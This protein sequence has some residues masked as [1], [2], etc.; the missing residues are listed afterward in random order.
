MC[1]D[2]GGNT[3]SEVTTTDFIH[4]TQAAFILQ[5]FISQSMMRL[6]FSESILGIGQTW[7]GHGTDYPIIFTPL[8]I[9]VAWAAKL[10]D[11]SRASMW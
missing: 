11:K 1:Y 4:S 8:L 6:P 10:Q 3:L 7:F 2:E 5:Y 9:H